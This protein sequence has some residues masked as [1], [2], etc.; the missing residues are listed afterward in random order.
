M[1]LKPSL[2]RQKGVVALLGLPA[3]GFLLWLDKAVPLSGVVALLLLSVSVGFIHGALD[4]V[5]LPKRFASRAQASAMFAAYF[6]LVLVLGWVLSLHIS[7]ALWALLLMSAWHFGEP[8]G[9]WNGLNTFTTGLTRIMVGGAPVMLPV[10]LA[11]EQLAIILTGVVPAEG[12][13]GWHALAMVWLA[14]SVVWLPI[15]MARMRL[16]RYAW[17]ELLGCVLLYS[18]FSPLMAFA[19]YFGAYHAP[20]HIWRVWRSHATP[21]SS[22][23]GSAITALALT[24]L[25]TWLLG[26]ALWWFL[27]SNAAF[28]PDWAAALRWL[29]VVFAALTAPHLVLISLCAAFLT[30][31][32]PSH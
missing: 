1:S 17:F 31:E 16:L 22:R 27:L 13:Q 21:A 7:L 30:A 15:G 10:W 8:Y 25:L 24:T 26:A 29:I 11:P 4:A 5:L 6:L 18:L 3:L 19:L 12:Q 14:L 9:R 32:R 23:L 20:A 28:A 2:Y